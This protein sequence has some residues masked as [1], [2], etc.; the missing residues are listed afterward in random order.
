ML[1]GAAMQAVAWLVRPISDVGLRG[2]EFFDVTVAPA[3]ALRPRRHAGHRLPGRALPAVDRA[4]GRAG[5]G[6]DPRVLHQL[7]PHRD[8]AG[9]GGHG[10]LGRAP[11]RS[12][13]GCCS[14]WRSRPSST[15]WSSS[16]RCCCC[17]CGPGRLRAVRRDR[18]LRR[19]RLA[20]G[21]PAGGPHRAHRL[22]PVLPLSDTR[23]RGL[24]LRLVLLRN[25]AL[26]VP[27]HA[28][29][30]GSVNLFSAADLR[31]R[32]RT[33]RCPDLSPLPRRPRLPQVFFL[34]LA[35]F[36]LAQQGVVA[37]IRHLAGAVRRAG[38]AA[39]VVVPPLAGGRGRVLLRDLGLPDHRAAD[40]AG[41][42]R[43]RR[44][45][46]R[47]VL[48]GAAVTVRHRRCSSCV[49]VTRDILR[50]RRRTWSAPA[51]RTTRP[52]GSSP[53]PPDRFVLRL[54]PRP[55][56]RRAADLT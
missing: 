24:G 28:H 51:G 36:L 21:Q 15:R 25:R 19:R 20:R 29:R 7:G 34:V 6:P 10:R 46:P 1:I 14:A 43:R 54:R 23:S 12:W 42:G 22:G 37:A 5:A 32:L 52:A 27:R 4:A 13:P 55:A 40:P 9:R 39:A 16:A 8:G 33:H 48:R 2:R 30:I 38:P 56:F 26:A 3:G 47:A 11:A 53:A 44:H 17:A 49:L 31:G 18:G 45:R 41:A 35:V 50:T